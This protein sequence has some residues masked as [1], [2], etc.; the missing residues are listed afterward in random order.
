MRGRR[1]KGR[2]A[3]RA[4]GRSLTYQTEIATA[5]GSPSK[6][7]IEESEIGRKVSGR[8]PFDL[9]D[10]RRADPKQH[11]RAERRSDVPTL[12]IALGDHSYIDRRT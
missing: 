8:H 11:A 2:H 6:G 9:A 3:A 12:V 5:L 10:A 4:E 1:K 7:R